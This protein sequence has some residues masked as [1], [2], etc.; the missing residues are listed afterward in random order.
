MP[1]MGPN[2][3]QARETGREVGE[4]LLRTL[5]K[6]YNLLDITQDTY[7]K[8][9]PLGFLGPPN[10]REEWA[11]TKERFIATVGSLFEQDA[12]NSF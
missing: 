10:A 6:Q 7:K 1:V 9:G 12:G 4:I 8:G 5:I 11:E 3:E 2:L